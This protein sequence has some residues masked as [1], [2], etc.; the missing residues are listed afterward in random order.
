MTAK[1]ASM[2][3]AH[4][5][6]HEEDPREQLMFDP[7]P[8]EEMNRMVMEAM[9][10]TNKAWWTAVIVLGILVA[11]CL[12]GAWLYMIV[13]GMGVAG[14]RRPTYW[15]IFIANFV[16]WIGISHAGTFVSAILPLP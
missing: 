10:D 13:K 7:K 9:E 5:A 3:H 16:F 15:G 4:H 2:P 11:V 6:E 12:F 8:R 1:A 14:I